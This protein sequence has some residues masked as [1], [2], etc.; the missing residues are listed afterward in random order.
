[1]SESSTTQ[2]YLK[3]PFTEFNG[4]QSPEYFKKRYSALQTKYR[5]SG[6]FTNTDGKEISY[7][8]RWEI[9]LVCIEDNSIYKE[10]HSRPSEIYQNFNLECLTKPSCF[11][12]L[13]KLIQGK[14]F[15]KTEVK[16]VNPRGIVI[17]NGKS[18]KL[19]ADDVVL[20]ETRKE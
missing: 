17:D 8:D 20:V 11:D 16:L 13:K 5:E 18:M 1:M 9:Q 14:L 3:A 2:K 4:V 15:N 12:E 7:P 10:E 19:L 6:S